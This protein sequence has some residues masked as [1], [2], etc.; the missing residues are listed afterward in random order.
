M[1]TVVG[2]IIFGIYLVALVYVTMYCLIQFHLL[3]HYK[4]HHWKKGKLSE[5]QSLSEGEYPMVTVQLPIF[6]EQYVV[7]RLIDNI[8]LI[9]YPREKIEFHILDD[10]TDETLAIS[11]RK[12][13]EYK[14][15]G[16]NIELLT[17]TDRSGYK[18]G[19]L[20]EATPQAKGEFICIFDAD[21]LPHPSFLKKTMPYF[22]QKDVGVVQAR[23][24]HIN[25]DYSLLTRLQAFQLNVHFTIEQQGRES[26]NFL[27]QFNGTA[28]V[29][30]KKCIEDAGGWE[31]D[32][33]TEDLDL[34][35]RAQIKGWKIAFLEEIGAP[36]ELPAEMHG[37]KSQQHRWM[38]GGAET[39]RKMLPT[40]WRSNLP[41]GQKLHGSAHLLASSVFL[42]VFIIGVF[43]VPLLFLIGPIGINM[44][45]LMIFLIS[46][47]ALIFVYLQAN[48]FT[49]WEEEN[50]FRKM[51]KFLLIFPLFLALSMGLAFHNSLAVIQGFLG[52]K[53]AFIR[54]PKYNLAGKSDSFLNKKYLNIK[55]NKGIIIEGLLALYF[56]FALVAG[57]VIQDGSFFLFHFFLTLGYGTIF[58]YSIKHLKYK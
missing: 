58:F 52:K 40:I 33:L 38:K 26:G 53:S 31:A 16:Y 45:N 9:D 49:N 17:R 8:I 43:S 54:T 15:K 44:D 23:W 18:A 19:A 14:K 13:D 57:F 48:V 3:V 29:W 11:Q 56:L 27:L 47:I 22:N 37:L 4:M 51:I 55:L 35:Y 32:T 1:I 46:L 20:K 7:E 50:R 42:C 21:F 2:N 24:E 5:E 6:N 34:S 12:I 28:G 36:A 25:R 41:L 39:A 10:S 30:R